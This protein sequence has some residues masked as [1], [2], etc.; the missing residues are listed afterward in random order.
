[1]R[2]TLHYSLTAVHYVSGFHVANRK[3][4]MFVKQIDICLC[5]FFVRHPPLQLEIF[6]P[7]NAPLHDGAIGV[8]EGIRKALD[9]L[10][11]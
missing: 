10:L 4:R 9:R 5:L 7:D 6:E 2:T 11:L 8:R 3:K 1:M